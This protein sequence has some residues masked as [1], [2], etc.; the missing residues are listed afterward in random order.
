MT[1]SIASTENETPLAVVHEF[2]DGLLANDIARV[3]ATLTDDV[4][5]HQPG[6]HPLAGS[7][8]GADVVLSAMGEF[9][10]RSEGTFRVE[11]L[12]RMATGNLVAVTFR[13]TARREGR[14][15]LDIRGVDLIRV[16]HGKIAEAWVFSSDVEAENKFWR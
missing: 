9:P 8:V 13:L 3:R 5:W 10:A 1:E 15:P 11:H 4:V 6:D 7:Y 2:F 14:A 16:E 12:D